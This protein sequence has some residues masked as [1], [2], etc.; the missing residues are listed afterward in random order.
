MP[1][2][3]GPA[4]NKFRSDFFVEIALVIAVAV[5]LVFAQG[6]TVGENLSFT[7]LGAGLMALATYWT[8]HTARDGLEVIALRLRP[9]K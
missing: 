7:V 4:R 6:Q 9:G 8:L 3:P 1:E 2:D 5:Y